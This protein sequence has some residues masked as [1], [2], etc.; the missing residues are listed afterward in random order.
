MRLEK[1][2]D[3]RLK[4][5]FCISRSILR[6]ILIKYL[7]LP[8]EEVIIKHQ[9]NGK[10]ALANQGIKL[11]FN[12]SH[13]DNWVLLAISRDCRVGIDL[14]KCNSKLDRRKIA[15]RVFDKNIYQKLAN[16]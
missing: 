13:T 11:N 15:K 9:K 16:Y 6:N 12:L 2:S 10:P 5:N 1:F 7:D 4:N 14:E 8:P 3:K